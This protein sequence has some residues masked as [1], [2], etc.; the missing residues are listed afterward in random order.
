MRE[1]QAVTGGA[2][3]GRWCWAAQAA[4]ALTGMQALASEA[5]AQGRDAADPVALAA[6][7]HRYR[8]A[9]LLGARQT[10]ARSGPLM[11][12][13]HALARRL[14][15]RQDDYLRFTPRPAD[16]SQIT[17]DLSAISAWPS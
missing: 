1:L 3:A 9:V 12:K 2:P 13:H 15:D 5:I 11:K 17:T 6:Q 10:A 14:R 4:D 8:S 16:P 7:V